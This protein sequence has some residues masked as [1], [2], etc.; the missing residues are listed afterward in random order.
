MIAASLALASFT[1]SGQVLGAYL[2]NF[3]AAV[4]NVTLS[5]YI[6]DHIRKADLARTEPLRLS[7]STFSWVLGPALGVWLYD[8]AGPAGTQ[9]AAI[10]CA[11]LLL[12]VFWALRLSDA[13][14]LPSGTMTSFNP[15]ANVR[16]FVNQPRLR[17]AW[18]IAFGRSCFWATFFIY[19]PLLVVEGNLSK[20]TAGFMISASQ[21]LLL[22]AWAFGRWAAKVGVRP[23]ISLCFLVMGV[24]SLGAGMAGSDHA[25][26]AIVLLLVGS[27]A[28]AG[29][30]AVGGIPFLRAVRFHE[31]QRMAAVYRT[32]IDLSELLPSLFFALA[33]TVFPLGIVFVILGFLLAAVGLVAWRHLPRSM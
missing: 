3:G 21:L 31:R 13:K 30:D 17:L 9:F 33:L 22:T 32:Y 10:T 7:L 25:A 20:Q 18:A 4:L 26:I 12:G 23:I 5:L 15:I 8:R 1:V 14:M 16:R 2:R 29:V 27:L 24:A 6:L 28:A 11:L 19:G